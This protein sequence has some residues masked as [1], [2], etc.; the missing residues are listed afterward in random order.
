MR[1]HV[2]DVNNNNQRYCCIAYYYY[3]Y[4]RD[5]CG[6]TRSLSPLRILLRLV[7]D[8][9]HNTHDL[10]PSHYIMF[11]YA[12]LLRI[13]KPRYVVTLSVYIKTFG[14]FSRVNI[15]F[16]R[17]VYRRYTRIMRTMRLR[18]HVQRYTLVPHVSGTERTQGQTLTRVDSNR[19]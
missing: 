6:N 16:A 3:C 14:R 5:G 18:Y 12:Y 9:V 7:R 11:R 1:G 2:N 15:T 13:P 4:V 8:H 17:V 10:W 19:V